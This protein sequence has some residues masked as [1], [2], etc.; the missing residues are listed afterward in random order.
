LSDWEKIGAIPIILSKVSGAVE[1]LKAWFPWKEFSQK[2]GDFAGEVA[3]AYNEE[4]LYVMG[5]IKDGTRDLLPSLLSGRNLHKFQNPPGD[6]VYYEAGPFPGGSG[7]VFKLSLSPLSE[8]YDEKYD[9]FPPNLPLQRLGHYISAVYQYLLYPI[10]EGGGEI[11]RVRTPDFFYLHP[12]PINY[13]FLAK[14]CRVNGSKIEVRL[15]D[16]GYIFE[17]QVPW[18]ELRE[19]K[20]E[21]GKRIKMSFVIQNGNMGNTLEFSRGKSLCG[22]NTL[23]FEPGWGAKYTAETEFEFVE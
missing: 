15:L 12:L 22:I 5:R 4:N 23:D 3:F 13:E 16:E 9:V 2:V 10:K 11:M 20:P 7:D 6:Y 1:A 21:V 18:S 17:A 19:I 14:A 8:N